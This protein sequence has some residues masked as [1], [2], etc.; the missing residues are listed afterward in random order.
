MRQ[1][2]Q[3]WRVY[4]VFDEGSERVICCGRTKNKKVKQLQAARCTKRLK[5]LLKLSNNVGQ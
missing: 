4:K 3:N 5:N 2:N 1:K